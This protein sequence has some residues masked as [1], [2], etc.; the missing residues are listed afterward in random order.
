MRRMAVFID[1]VTAMSLT[2]GSTVRVSS[3]QV[4]QK[5]QVMVSIRYWT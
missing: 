2:V 3:W 1:G 4:K 5:T